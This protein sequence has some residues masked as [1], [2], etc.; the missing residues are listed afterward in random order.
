MPQLG[1]VAQG[2]RAA[3]RNPTPGAVAEFEIAPLGP[4]G[5]E[6]DAPI[7]EPVG[8]AAEEARHLPGPG[9]VLEARVHPRPRGVSDLRS[10][11][12]AACAR[13]LR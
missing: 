8:A 5:Q 11:G 3:V 9:V 13:R 10:L 2:L 7:G 1:P 6:P 12:T 4:P